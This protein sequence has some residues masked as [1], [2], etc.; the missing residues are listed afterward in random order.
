LAVAAYTVRS[1]ILVLKGFLLATK[2]ITAVGASAPIS[3]S[4]HKMLTET[5][6]KLDDLKFPVA[7]GLRTVKASVLRRIALPMIVC[8]IT[9]GSP[10]HDISYMG[11]ADWWAFF[12]TVFIQ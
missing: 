1:G 2:Y 7:V 4:L 5:A 9:G 12:I 11:G 10:I 8:Q 6:F 3:L